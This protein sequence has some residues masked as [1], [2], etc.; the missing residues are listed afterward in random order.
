AYIVEHSGASLLLLDP[1][2][3]EKLEGVSCA[4]KV[5]L[6]KEADELLYTAGGAPRTWQR[7]E[8]ATATI[9]YTSGTTARPKGVQ[10]THRNLWL[11]SV[12]FGL[13]NTIRDPDVL[14]HTL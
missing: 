8:S 7:D 12:V 10:L 13:H 4:R 6:G 3:A 5:V 9:N 11:N 14:P 1:E 2:L